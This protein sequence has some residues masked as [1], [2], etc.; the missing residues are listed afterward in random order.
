MS[1]EP[2]D[3]DNI[4]VRGHKRA[5]GNTELDEL[6]LRSRV[7]GDTP[8]IASRKP[9]VV[10][11]GGGSVDLEVFVPGSVE[12]DRVRTDDG[13]V[14]LRGVNGDATAETDDG[15]IA[16]SDVA[17]DLD[18]STDDGDVIVERTDGVVRARAAAG[19]IVVRAPNAVGDLRTDDG[20]IVA[21]VPTVDGYG[22]PVSER[23]IRSAE[24]T[25]DLFVGGDEGCQHHSR[26]TREM[27]GVVRREG[28]TGGGGDDLPDEPSR[29]PVP[30][31][32]GHHEREETDQSET[33][34]VGVEDG[35]HRL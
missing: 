32:N 7:D 29:A 28:D 20:D 5:H 21:E 30:D 3:G 27:T 15:D 26:P 9:D 2:A 31:D 34:R 14:S 25:V 19:D 8:R 16:A 33:G 22:A 1:V 23:G 13:S 17:G 11:I 24:A 10:C 18:A 4:R 6:A 12:V 35:E